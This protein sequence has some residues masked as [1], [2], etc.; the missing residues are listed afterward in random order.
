VVEV[1]LWTLNTIILTEEEVEFVRFVVRYEPCSRTLQIRPNNKLERPL[2]RVDI[3]VVSSGFLGSLKNNLS[4]PLKF[5]RHN[6]LARHKLND[7]TL[8]VKTFLH[9]RSNGLQRTL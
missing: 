2:H 6:E 5:R 7:L 1:P 4:S 3:V 9:Y 8:R